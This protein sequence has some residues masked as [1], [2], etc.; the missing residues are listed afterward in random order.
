MCKGG[1]GGKLPLP[2]Q[3]LPACTYVQRGSKFCF[4]TVVAAA[5]A[6]SATHGPPRGR[7]GSGR[8]RG[9]RGRG[10]YGGGGYGNGVFVTSGVILR[11]LCYAAEL[12]ENKIFAAE[13]WENKNFAAEFFFSA[14]Q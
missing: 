12:W 5:A 13:L 3:F 1:G 7:G 10:Y 11:P 9:R 14:E 8:G 2:W 4:A 6:T